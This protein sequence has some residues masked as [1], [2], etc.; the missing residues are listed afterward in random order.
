MTQCLISLGALTSVDHIDEFHLIYQDAESCL[1]AICLYMPM[2][3]MASQRNARILIRYVYVSVM[4]C[5][6]TWEKLNKKGCYCHAQYVD[7]ANHRQPHMDQ[8]RLMGQ[9]WCSCSTLRRLCDY[10]I[11][12]CDL[13]SC[14]HHKQLRVAAQRDV[15]NTVPFY[16]IN[17]LN[18]CLTIA[19]WMFCILLDLTVLTSTQQSLE[20]AVKAPKWLAVL[21]MF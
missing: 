16:L 1:F 20:K 7:D 4:M 5:E 14:V 6:T 18:F 8:W 11:L 13:L 2:N 3:C 15:Q 19:D 10:L 9:Q 12:M 21:P 17:I